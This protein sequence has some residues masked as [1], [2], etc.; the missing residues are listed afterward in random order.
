MVIIE[1]AMPSG[2]LIEADR[3]PDLLHQPHNK[4]VET[5]RGE[6]VADIYIE[7]MLA[8]EELCLEVLGYRSHK[9]A[10]TRP[11]LVRKCASTI[12]TTAVCFTCI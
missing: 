9:V 10:E 12:I 3:L 2:F 6:T 7:Q 4:L 5:K 8:N 11:A 1:V